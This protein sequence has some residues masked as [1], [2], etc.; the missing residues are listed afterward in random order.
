MN[1]WQELGIPPTRDLRAIKRAYAA[2]LRQ[3]HPEEDA[4]GF[5]R[6][7]SAY[8]SARREARRGGADNRSPTRPPGRA[9]NDGAAAPAGATVEEKPPGAERFSPGRAGAELAVRFVA[10]ADA[11][12]QG[13][14]DRLRQLLQSPLLRSLV[15]R[16]QFELQ[17]LRELLVSSEL[18][19]ALTETCIRVLEWNDRRNPLWREGLPMLVTRFA[20][21]K[22]GQRTRA[23]RGE[24]AAIRAGKKGSRAR[25]NALLALLGPVQPWRYRW[26]ALSA[27]NRQA[28]AQF[29]HELPRLGQHFFERETEAAAVAWWRRE[30]AR[31]HLQTFHWLILVGAAIA[32][33]L[34]SFERASDGPT[35]LSALVTAIPGAALAVAMVLWLLIFSFLALGT[36]ELLD[37]RRSTL[38]PAIDRAIARVRHTRRGRSWL[39]L[40]FLSLTGVLVGVPQAGVQV[41]AALGALLLIGIAFGRLALR[42]SPVSVPW[43]L[44]GLLMLQPLL[45]SGLAA[46]GSAVLVSLPVHCGLILVLHDRLV[47]RGW[48]IERIGLW[49]RGLVLLFWLLPLSLLTIVGALW[50]LA[51]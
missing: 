28:V 29:L 44:L 12:G 48:T 43:G 9:A 47:R 37:R 35:A 31:P 24:L 13:M 20:E 38:A 7:R 45:P 15:A 14:E 2:R 18:P 41:L 16:E 10:T 33:A 36:M 5:Q 30:L 50:P 32:A 22:I 21:V 46:A 3:V 25:R 27:E 11:S 34:V 17:L 4:E 40:L 26:L 49:M 8:E 39:F 6:L 19:L 23:M 42:L 51:R 1:V